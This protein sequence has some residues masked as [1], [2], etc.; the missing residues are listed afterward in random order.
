VHPLTKIFVLVSSVLALVLSALTVSYAVNTDKVLADYR[1]ALARESAAMAA[2]AAGASA[3]ASKEQRLS[4]QIEQLQRDNASASAQ[5]RTLEAERATLLTERNKSELARQG[6]EGKIAELGETAST[7]ATIIDS[8]RK[9]VT[10]LRA[11]ELSFRQRSLEMEDRLSDLESQREVLEQNYRAL[12]E[13]LAQIK[14]A[15][16]QTLAGGG[17]TAPSAGAA[18]QPVV[19]TGPVIQGRVE[20]V[21]AHPATGRNIIKISVGSNDRV[22]QGMKFLVVRDGRWAGNLIVQQTDMQWSIGKQGLGDVRVG[23]LVQSSSM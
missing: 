20:E 5:I 10:T 9:E 18:D 23:D 11:N 15:S 12:Q 6:I 16:A 13:E 7:Q 4:A 2:T 17:T 22:V 21:M 1:N 19:Y 8:Y 3:S 14:Q